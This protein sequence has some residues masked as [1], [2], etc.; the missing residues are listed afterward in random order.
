MSHDPIDRRTK[1]QMRW[2]LQK[3]QGSHGICKRR[4]H[5]DR[6]MGKGEVTDM[7]AIY[8]MY[9]GEELLATG[10]AQELAD[11]DNVTVKTIYWRTSPTNSKR[12]GGKRKVVVRIDDGGVENDYK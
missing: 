6:H 3:Y 9:K 4:R 2:M 8:A 1:K 7:A 11:A 12:D 5:P 10:M